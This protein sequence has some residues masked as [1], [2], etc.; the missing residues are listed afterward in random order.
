ME[1]SLAIDVQNKNSLL[2]ENTVK[3]NHLNL[4]QFIEIEYI[5]LNMRNIIRLFDLHTGIII[6]DIIF[7]YVPTKSNKI[8]NSNNFHYFCARV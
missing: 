7:K 1:F 5:I 4:L 6:I 2:I 8:N 3:E